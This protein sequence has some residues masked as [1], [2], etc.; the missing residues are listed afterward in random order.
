MFISLLLKY[1]K[2]SLLVELVLN[3]MIFI[4]VKMYLFFKSSSMSWVSISGKPESTALNIFVSLFG[5]EKE[6]ICFVFNSSIIFVLSS[7]EFGKIFHPI[8]INLIWLLMPK[9]LRIISIFVLWSV[10]IIG[11]TFCLLLDAS[12]SAILFSSMSSNLNWLLSGT[13]ICF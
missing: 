11:E 9:L 5:W 12:S 6:L 8:L 4:G 13:W 2:Y 3:L 1:N 7:R 10:M